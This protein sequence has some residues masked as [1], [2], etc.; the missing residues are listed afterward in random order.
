MKRKTLVA[1]LAAVMAMSA[2]TGCGSGN[3][4]KAN[5][6]AGDS[7]VTAGDTTA[8]DA[9]AEITISAS[10]ENL[11]E[12][13][14]EVTDVTIE[15]DKIVIG[16][17]KGVEIEKVETV[18]VTEEDIDEAVESL[19]DEYTTTEEITDRTDVQNGDIA[20]ID[21][22]GKIDGVA[23]EGGTDT[24]FD[25]EIGSD[26]FIDG[27]E[28]G[29]IGAKVGETVDVKVTFPDPYLNNTELSGKEAV[30]TVTVNA[31]QKEVVPELTDAF[32]AEKTDSA[33]IAEY[34]EAQRTQLETDNAEYAQYE[35][36]E[37]AWSA[38]LANCA[39]KEYDK[40]LVKSNAISYKEYVSYMVSYSGGSLEDYVAEQMGSTM[41][42]FD[43]EAVE[44]G[45]IAQKEELL[46]EAIAEKEGL[47]LTDEEYAEGVKDTYENYGYDNEDDFWAAV[48]EQGIDREEMEKNIRDSKLYEKVVKMVAENAIEVEPATTDGDAE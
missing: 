5:T 42:E 9:T 21:Y 13:E 15:T 10:F 45:K 11:T 22:E 18:A 44:Q 3:K 40:D 33:T 4:D 2:F 20:N 16:Q 8:G 32:I 39:V 38:V 36:E 37:A 35:K 48:E 7:A 1:I 46:V 47:E 28:D 31:I 29:L 34:R 12:G 27:F 19:V 25:L 23:F 30:F 24:G 26:S 17:Y 14:P 43:A 6:T 41:E